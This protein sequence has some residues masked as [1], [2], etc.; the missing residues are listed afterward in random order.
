[1]TISITVSSTFDLRGRYGVRGFRSLRTSQL[2]VTP[3]CWTVLDGES[4]AHE[5]AVRKAV[6]RIVA[7]VNGKGGW[8]YVGWLRTGAVADQSGEMAAFKDVDNISSQSQDPHIS[9]LF[10]TDPSDV[11]DS[12]KAFQQLR[13][14]TAELG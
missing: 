10:P 1:M 14:Q 6:S 8:T 7:Y 2:F 13:L 9:Y 5:K 4:K 11:S 12:D 3:D